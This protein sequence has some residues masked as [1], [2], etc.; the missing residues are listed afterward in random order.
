MIF[1][2]KN[3]DGV[4]TWKL[5]L[6]GKKTVTRRFKPMPVGKEF[7]IQPGRGK[8]AVAKAVV[9][10]CEKH[11]KW[12]KSHCICFRYSALEYKNVYKEDLEKPL[13]EEARL[14]GFNSYFRLVKW[15][16]DKNIIIDDTY[17]IEFKLIKEA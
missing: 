8:K 4:P 14:E 5:V 10:N 1:C 13:H 16:T 15:L 3:E 6:E 9:V 12:A 7:A 17:R 2:A 11:K